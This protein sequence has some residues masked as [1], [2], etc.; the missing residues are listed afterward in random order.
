VTPISRLERSQHAVGFATARWKRHVVLADH[1]Y[2]AKRGA[3]L[4]KGLGS[5]FRMPGSDDERPLPSTR[6]TVAP[7]L[8]SRRS[9]ALR[10]DNQDAIQQPQGGARFA[11]VVQQS[12]G[13]QIWIGLILPQQRAQ[14]GQRVRLLCAAHPIEER[15]KSRGQIVRDQPCILGCGLGE[16]GLKEL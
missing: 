12:R 5:P 2:Q 13:E 1:V 14:H 10:E 11:H 7:G 15:P 3:G 6:C 8:S 4:R 16:Q 9:H